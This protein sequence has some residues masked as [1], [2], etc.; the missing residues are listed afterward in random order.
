[1]TDVILDRAMNLP[2]KH[3]LRAY[4]AVQLAVALTLN[5]FVKQQ[6]IQPI[7]FIACDG[8]LLTAAIAEQLYV[9]DPL[10]HP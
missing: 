10:Q 6:G 4:D 2:E 7:V 3:K 5:D 8:D 9:D 1:M